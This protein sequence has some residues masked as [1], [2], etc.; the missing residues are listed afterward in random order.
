ME[1]CLYKDRYAIGGLFPMHQRQTHVKRLRY[2]NGGL[3]AIDLR[4]LEDLANDARISIADLAVARR[5]YACS[6]ACDPRMTV[7]CADNT[8]PLP[9]TSAVSAC[10]TWRAPHSPRN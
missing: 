10:A 3:D 4:L 7:A 1:G 8:P 9:C 5:A 2:E 6:A